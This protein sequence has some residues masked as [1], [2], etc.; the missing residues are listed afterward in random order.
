MME[1]GGGF[2]EAASCPLDQVLVRIDC[3]SVDS[4]AELAAALAD[5]SPPDGSV[6]LCSGPTASKRHP[7][8]ARRAR[9]G[10]HAAASLSAVLDAVPL[11]GARIDRPNLALT[12]GAGRVG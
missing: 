11:V 9:S 6:T 3:G 5:A 12:L 2:A 7:L 10:R 4:V 1:Q 8:L